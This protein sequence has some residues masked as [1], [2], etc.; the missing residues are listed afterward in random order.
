MEKRRGSSPRHYWL[1]DWRIPFPFR[2]I[3]WFGNDLDLVVFV[4]VLEIGVNRMDVTTVII[5]AQHDVGGVTG[6]IQ[7]VGKGFRIAEML[8]WVMYEFHNV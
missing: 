1:S 6:G 8:E 2:V 7:F 5:G 4:P 3:M